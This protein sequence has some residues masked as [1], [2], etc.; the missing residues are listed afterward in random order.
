MTPT[1]V[2]AEMAELRGLRIKN[3]TISSYLVFKST[4]KI[5]VV[6]KKGLLS[7]VQEQ[8]HQGVVITGRKL[9]VLN[10]LYH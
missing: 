9:K 10:P 5:E 1:E 6:E 3:H 4:L 2:D 7:I 8:I